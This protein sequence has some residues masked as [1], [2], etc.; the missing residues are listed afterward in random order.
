MLDESEMSKVLTGYML[1]NVLIGNVEEA[2]G[3]ERKA[4]RKC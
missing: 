4:D 1:Q 3:E 2:C